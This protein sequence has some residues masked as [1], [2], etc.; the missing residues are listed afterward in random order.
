MRRI[1]KR[2]SYLLLL[3]VLLTTN[4]LF[5]KAQNYDVEVGI[6]FSGQSIES[7]T[8]HGNFPEGGTSNWQT[9]TDQGGTKP[10]QLEQT[11]LGKLPT[12]GDQFSVFGLIIG[13]ECL[14]IGCSLFLL[15]KRKEDNDY[16]R[17]KKYE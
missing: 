1:I 8:P 3:S 14:A 5:T 11:A 10:N 12:T 7:E 13:M 4:P 15:Q 2:S 6:S 16:G 9:P 17:S